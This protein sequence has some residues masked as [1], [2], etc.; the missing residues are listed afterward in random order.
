MSNTTA[1]RRALMWR[2]VRTYVS[3]EGYEREMDY[4]SVELTDAEWDQ[5]LQWIDVA[6]SVLAENPAKPLPIIKERIGYTS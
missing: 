6:S 5:L 3:D 1:H 4:C 2:A